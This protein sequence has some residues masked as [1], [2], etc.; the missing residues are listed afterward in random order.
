MI[1]PVK[2]E[3]PSCGRKQPDKGQRATCSG[4]GY[5]PVPSYSYPKRCCFHAEWNPVKPR[6]RGPVALRSGRVARS[7]PVDATGW[8]RLTR[9]ESRQRWSRKRRGK[10]S[11][12]N[13]L[14]SSPLP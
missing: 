11:S 3:C 1:A 9:L 2:V 8:E 7:R 14:R 5:S 4:C 6:K 13:R 10:W 12:R